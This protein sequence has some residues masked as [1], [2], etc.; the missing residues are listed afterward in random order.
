[1]KAYLFAFCFLFACLMGRGQD[2]YASF[3][4]DWMEKAAAAKPKLI[5]RMVKAEQVV[6]LVAD[7][8][9]F[10]G[11]GME[12]V[13]EIAAFKENGFKAQSGL[14]IDFGEHVTGQV[15]LKLSP[16]DV[17]ADAPTRLKLTFAEIPSEYSVPFDPY[18]GGL[19]RAWLQDEIITVMHLPEQ[20]T[21]PRR[22]SFRYVKIELLSPSQAYD[23][24]IDDLEVEAQSSANGEVP[25]LSPGLSEQLRRIDRI[26]LNT[27]KECMQTVYEDGPK[28]DQRLWIG[29]LYLE[30]LTNSFTFKNHQLT[31]RCLYLLAQLSDSTGLLHGTVL[32][33]PFPQAQ[34]GQFL[35]DYSLLYNVALK[36][37]LLYS[38]DRETVMD[39]W[40]VARRQVDLAQKYIERDQVDFAFASRENWIFIDWKDGLDREAAFTGLLLFAFGETLQLAKSLGKEKELS[41]LEKQIARIRKMAKQRFFEQST[42]LVRS[43]KEGQLS[44]ASAIWATLGGVL[45]QKTAAKTWKKTMLNSEAVRPGGPYLY[46]FYIEALIE[47][48]LTMHARNELTAY[49]G[50]MADKGAD[51]FWEVFDP[52]DEK[53]S[54]YG[55]FPVNSYCHAWSCT[56]AYFFR[57][58]PEVFANQ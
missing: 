58:Y 26:A 3:R 47:A 27:L 46:H 21:I 1:M 37:Y 16:K 2:P 25:A 41:G 13:S 24:F 33:Q 56:P 12:P 38:K 7:E 17:T 30:A 42:G 22:L 23:F 36:D 55:F 45:D 34:K 52:Q 44:Y 48:G 51:T 32:E 54:P 49:W 57:R 31:K 35:L 4:Q 28:R 29:D 15:R 5:K 53:R 18:P 40:P 11:W 10:Q 9:K 43:G 19:S 6:K 39:L 8:N 20:V 14:I 50:A